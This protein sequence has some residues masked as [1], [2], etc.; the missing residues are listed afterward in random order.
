[1]CLM[2]GRRLENVFV[3]QGVGAKKVYELEL[4]GPLKP[5]YYSCSIIDFY[6]MPLYNLEALN[7]L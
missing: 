5:Y 2:T 7:K 6:I 4:K 3:Y 1:M